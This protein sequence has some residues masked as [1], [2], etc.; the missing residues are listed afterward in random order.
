MKPAQKIQVAAVI[1]GVGFD[2]LA[3]SG[4]LPIPEPSQ[5]LIKH[6]ASATTRTALREKKMRLT[7][8][9]NTRVV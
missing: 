6:P 2:G 9:S 7:Q 3:E 5:P 1:S 8:T 4:R